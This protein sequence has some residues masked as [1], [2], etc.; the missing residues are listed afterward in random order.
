[1]SASLNV[2][3]I[4]YS[5]YSIV[6]L[7]YHSNGRSLPSSTKRSD[8]RN[9]S[10]V[11]DWLRA[12]AA[13]LF[14]SLE[15]MN[16]PKIPAKAATDCAT[17][18]KNQFQSILMVSPVNLWESIRGSCFEG[19]CSTGITAHRAFLYLIGARGFEP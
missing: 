18:L 15:M 6:R 16:A 19:K 4:S 8:S 10:V 12:K 3:P 2:F 13:S 9:N 14:K 7:L 17:E 1:M 5:A 11:S